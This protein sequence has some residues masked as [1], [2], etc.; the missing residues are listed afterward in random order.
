[1]C[2]LVVKPDPRLSQE[3]RLGYQKVVSSGQKWRRAEKEAAESERK[4]QGGKARLTS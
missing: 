4:K 3:R 2:Y 1:L